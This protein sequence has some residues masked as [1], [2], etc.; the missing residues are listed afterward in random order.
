MDIKETRIAE[1]N[2][3]IRLDQEYIEDFK[4]NMA[5]LTSAINVEKDNIEP[6]RFNMLIANLKKV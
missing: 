2:L 1:K 5:K 4:S 6:T 3:T